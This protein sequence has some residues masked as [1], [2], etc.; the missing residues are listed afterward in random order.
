MSDS[1][2]GKRRSLVLSAMGALIALLVMYPL[3]FGPACW[4]VTRQDLPKVHDIFQGIY[5]P[6]IVA[7]LQMPEEMDKPV[8]WYLCLG[9]P[10]DSQPTL[11]TWT[12]VKSGKR[13]RIL[14]WNRPGYSYT[15]GSMWID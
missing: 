3:S 5:G 14:I 13:Y 2:G 7:L 4:I 15:A 6:L 8:S 11:D 9:A 10:T 1:T 12:V